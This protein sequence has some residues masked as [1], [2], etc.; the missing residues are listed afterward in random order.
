[1]PKALCKTSSPQYRT[2]FPDWSGPRPLRFFLLENLLE[3]RSEST[4][5]TNLA[6]PDE[7]VNIY[8]A[9][10]LTRFLQGH[11]PTDILFGAQPL[12]NP[13]AKEVDRRR[14]A[15]FYRNNA[16][17][18]LLTLGLF[19]R[20][21]LVRKR[22]DLFGMSPQETQQRDLNV[23]RDCYLMAVNLLENRNILNPGIVDVWRKLGENF[24]LYIQVLSTMAITRLGLGAKLTG[25]D[26]S[27]LMSASPAKTTFKEP[28]AE[29][30][31]DR[32]LDLLLEIRRPG[33][34]TERQKKRAEIH[35]LALHLDLDPQ[36]LL[37]QAG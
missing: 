24:D 8:L 28:R 3:A 31:M 4:F 12:F 32:L 37:Q 14:R 9:D 6:G 35:D 13:P 20:G 7:D 22:G 26:L 16:D 27:L 23:G 30:S 29:K 19:N 2:L 10:L 17:H 15:E 18:R 36:K 1:M 33:P 21:E 25:N 11:H 34:S 5:P